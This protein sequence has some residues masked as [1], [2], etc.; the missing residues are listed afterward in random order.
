M[1]SSFWPQ[2]LSFNRLRFSLPLRFQRG[3]MT[4]RVAKLLLAFL[5]AFSLVMSAATGALFIWP[6]TDKPVRAD[7]I[8][9]FGGHEERLATG[10]RLAQQG[11]APALVLTDPP[12]GNRLCA[13]RRGFEVVCVR[14][15]S[16][17][18]RGEARVVSKLAAVRGW[19]SLTLVT[20]SYHVTRARTLLDRCYDGRVDV[21]G[22]SSDTSLSRSAEKVLHEWGGLAYA[23]SIGRDC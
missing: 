8:V 9:V 18:T 14:P 1:A 13:R 20:S 23:Y 10:I 12:D 15:E 22:A 21:V 17:N 5:V 3:R 11:L 4:I 7:A 19:K 2:R 6:P 16:F